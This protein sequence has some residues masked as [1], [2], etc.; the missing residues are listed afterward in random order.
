MPPCNAGCPAGENIQAWLAHAR[1]GRHEQAWRQL[2]ADNPFAAIHGRVCYHPC[3]SVCN[4]A[5]LDAAVS[6]HAVERFLGDTARDSGWQFEPPP[7]PTGKRVLTLSTPADT[8]LPLTW[9][10]LLHSKIRA[11]LAA[12]TGVERASDV[13]KYLLA[14]ADVVQ[15]ASALLRHGPEYAGV[16]LR[17]LS[18]W[19]NRKKFSN[20]GEVRGLLA[21][22]DAKESEAHERA[23]YVWALRKANSGIYDI[24]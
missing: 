8:R 4:R 22:P 12:S 17:E 19:M 21:A 15:S 5:H 24:Y 9:I 20:L 7:Q 14:G 3:E 23:D 10:T 1:A 13:A 16:L 18:H 2:V 6:I 11:S